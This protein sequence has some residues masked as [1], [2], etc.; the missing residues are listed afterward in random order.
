VARSQ[1]FQG[2]KPVDSREA[3]VKEHEVEVRLRFDQVE[4]AAAVAGFEDCD[5]AIEITE[6]PAQCSAYQRVIVYDKYL[7]GVLEIPRSNRICVWL[8]GS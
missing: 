7:H 6:N 1:L 5:I 4:R 2:S 3:Q 8:M